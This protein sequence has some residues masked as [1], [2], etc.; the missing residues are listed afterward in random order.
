MG[1]R[2]RNPRGART[3]TEGGDTRR[4]ECGTHC[5]PFALSARLRPRM[6]R[7]TS[8][9]APSRGPCRRRAR[10]RRAP[11][12]CAD[13]QGPPHAR[14][15]VLELLLQVLDRA[16][17]IVAALRRGL[18][19]G[20]ISK[21]FGIADARASLLG[22]DLAVEL[23]GIFREFADHHFDAGEIA[24][25]FFGREPLQ[26][27]KG[28]SRFHQNATPTQTKARRVW[29]GRIARDE[30]TLL[31]RGCLFVTCLGCCIVTVGAA[32]KKP[33]LRHFP[34]ESAF[35]NQWSVGSRISWGWRGSRRPPGLRVGLVRGRG[36]RQ[37]EVRTLHARSA[38]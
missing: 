12:P 15:G 13:R 38:D 31:G 10:A 37:A 9:R 5:T 24:S 4:G 33:Q 35:V 28:P 17:Q 29:R 18:G 19:I 14:R 6:V 7:R 3:E 32:L 30:V 8:S 22:R 2:V 1:S 27:D 26:T 34:L 25:L 11:R 16:A 21:M 23:G 20:R 36:G